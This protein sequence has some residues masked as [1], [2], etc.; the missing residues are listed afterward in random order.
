[1]EAFGSEIKPEFHFWEA[2]EI[3]GIPWLFLVIGG[4]FVGICIGIELRLGLG[5]GFWGG[6]GREGFSEMYADRVEAKGKL[7]VRDRLNGS[8]VSGDPSRH[9]QLT[10]KRSSSA[11]SLSLFVSSRIGFIAGKVGACE[12][13][14]V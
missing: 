4:L 3:F 9:R 5:L 13:V 12:V 11:L 10:G 1:M 7:S 6:V 8:S 14:L 2:Q